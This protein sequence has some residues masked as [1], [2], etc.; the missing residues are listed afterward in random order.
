V[1]PG[2]GSGSN[3]DRLRPL[4][5]RMPYPVSI[6]VMPISATQSAGMLQV[7]RPAGHPK[8]R[9]GLAICG[10]SRNGPSVAAAAEKVL[11][12]CVVARDGTVEHFIKVGGIV[13]REVAHTDTTARTAAEGTVVVQRVFN[14]KNRW[15]T[16]P[17]AAPSSTGACHEPRSLGLV[18]SVSAREVVRADELSNNSAP[19]TTSSHF[20]RSDRAPQETLARPVASTAV[21]R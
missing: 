2:I 7:T 5:S 18:A 19:P 12:R 9:S 8:R 13:G 20:R 16:T 14:R 17:C 6:G 3:S 1:W 11:E 21:S 15:T 10:P 4:R